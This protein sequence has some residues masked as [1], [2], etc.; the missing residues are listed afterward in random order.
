M[1][2]SVVIPTCNRPV[3]LTQ[4]L[5]GLT[6][7]DAEIIITDDGSDEAAHALLAQEFPEA[8]WFA[9]PRRGPAAN[10]NN[11]A[12]VAAGEWLVF[13]DDDCEPQPGWLTAFAAAADGADVLEGRTLAPGAQDSPFEEHV[14]NVRGGVLWSCNLA[15]RRDVFERLG[16]FDEDFREAGGEDM[17][18]AWRVTRAGLRVSFAPNAAVHHPP[19]AIG[20]SGLWRRTWMIRWMSLYRIKTSQ[21]HSL[22]MAAFDELLL[23]LRITGQLVT[24]PDARWPRRQYFNV[25]W[26]WLT[27]PVVLPWILYWEH[28]FRSTLES[29]LIS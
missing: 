25:F 4:C 13:I 22:P 28:R 12:R 18:F 26:R 2:F 1:K 19:R 5:R 3:L 24:R 27:F 29:R 23:L 11:G 7:E 15:V 21:A 9:G 6:G 16:G 17:E 10:R 8:R 14:E 20:W